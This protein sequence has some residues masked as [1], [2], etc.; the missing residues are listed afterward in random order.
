MCVC[1]DPGR[2][3]PESFG[4]AEEQSDA[5]QQTATELHLKRAADGIVH[6]ELQ[7]R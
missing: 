5:D 2:S 1:S 4:A 3:D 6:V 7:P